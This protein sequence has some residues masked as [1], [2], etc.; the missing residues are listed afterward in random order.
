[1]TSHVDEN[2]LSLLLVVQS[3]TVSMEKKS[4]V[5]SEE[6]KIQ[7]ILGSSYTTLGAYTQGL[8]H[9]TTRSLSQSFLLM[10]YL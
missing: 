7:S 3:H 1:M 4:V 9:H 8:L 2:N 10:L 6:D 5:V